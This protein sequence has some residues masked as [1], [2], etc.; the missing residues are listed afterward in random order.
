MAL[1]CNRSCTSFQSHAPSVVSVSKV[2]PCTTDLGHVGSSDPLFL[3]E[4]ERLHQHIAAHF[5]R[6]LRQIP[7]LADF[8]VEVAERGHPV[9]LA[10]R[11]PRHL[12]RQGRILHEEA[13]T[14]DVVIRRLQVEQ[15][16]S[17]RRQ[18]REVGPGDGRQKFT[19]SSPRAARNGNHSLSVTPAQNFMFL[20]ESKRNRFSPQ[21]RLHLDFETST[22]AGTWRRWSPAS[23]ARRFQGPR[24]Y[25]KQPPVR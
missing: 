13:A 17:A 18:A 15:E 20:K 8:P 24:A 23:G 19:S 11:I 16:G 5:Q 10:E 9:L 2:L 4:E 6:S 7:V 12:Q 25:G 1:S 3:R 14:R 22:G 21:H